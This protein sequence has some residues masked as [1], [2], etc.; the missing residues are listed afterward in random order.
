MPTPEPTDTRYREIVNA[1][2]AAGADDPNW[3]IADVSLR[4]LE[5]LKQMNERLGSL[6]LSDGR[7]IA[8][9]QQIE[10][11]CSELLRIQTRRR[12]IVHMRNVEKL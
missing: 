8:S 5:M 9:L 7:G 1:K 12:K 11:Y 2:L 4:M 3:I 6:T 10:V